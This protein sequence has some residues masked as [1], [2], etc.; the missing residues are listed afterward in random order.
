MRLPNV[1]LLLLALALSLIAGCGKADK[2]AAPGAAASAPAVKLLLAP[3]DL[4]SVQASHQASGPVV[5]GAV[6]PERRADLRAEVSAVVKQVLKDNGQPVKAGDL[7]VRLDDTSL[8]D[9]LSSANEAQRASS[10]QFEQA[11]RQVQRLKTLQTQGMVTTQALEDA[12]VRR[13][14]AQSDLAAA[15][16]RAVQARQQLQRTMVRAPFDG[17]V[18]E[19]KVSAGD[20][21]AVGKELLK[22]IDPS[23]MRFEGLISADRLGELKL[24]QPVRFDINGFGDKSFVGKL[25]RID[26]TVNA[27]TRQVAVVVAF[28]DPA[29]APRVAGLFAEGRIDT[30]GAQVISLPEGALVRAGEAAHVW[31]VGNGKISKVVVKL[32]ERDARTG[33]V[34]VLGGLATGE[35][36]L[37]NPGSGLVD[38]QSFEFAPA[39]TQAQR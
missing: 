4:L 21:A 28:D 17:V 15:R 1:E 20:T 9:S 13:N 22:V 6:Q 11:E 34:P 16:A 3:E 10:L 8:R 33:E 2:A 31:R 30:G 36:V 38:G 26:S 29:A 32:G 37:R 39:A 14:N 23:T 18:G 19:R 12:Q 25:Q 5:T 35:R 24:G 7:L 27:A